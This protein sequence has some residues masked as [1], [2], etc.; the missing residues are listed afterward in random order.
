MKIELFLISSH[1]E[2][3]GKHVCRKHWN[4][5]WRGRRGWAPGDK[6]PPRIKIRNESFGGLL[7]APDGK[8]YRLDE[9]AYFWMDLIFGN[10]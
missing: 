7:E 4:Y 8:L 1:E 6:N 2:Y 10:N 9:E 3:A 5:N